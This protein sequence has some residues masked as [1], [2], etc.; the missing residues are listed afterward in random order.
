M[1]NGSSVVSV[2][3]SAYTDS[4]SGSLFLS[5]HLF[6]IDLGS[7]CGSNKFGFSL[8]LL[9]LMLLGLVFADLGLV[10]WLQF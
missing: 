1:K 10:E 2:T 5:S 9:V 7:D 4:T 3:L 6:A 8:L